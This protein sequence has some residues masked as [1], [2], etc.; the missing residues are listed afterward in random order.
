[1]YYCFMHIHC[2]CGHVCFRFREHEVVFGQ[3]GSP[4]DCA[5]HL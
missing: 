3:Y 5:V 1:M 2:H 4:E